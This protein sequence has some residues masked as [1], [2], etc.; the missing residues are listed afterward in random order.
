M[1]AIGAPRAPVMVYLMSEPL[2]SP[3]EFLLTG[4]IVGWDI[5][6]A[7]LIATAVL[8]VAGGLLVQWTTARKGPIAVGAAGQIPTTSSIG[9]THQHLATRPAMSA[10]GAAA[11]AGRAAGIVRRTLLATAKPVLLAIVAQA[12]ILRYL[13]TSWVSMTLGAN[14]ALAV[15][16][17]AAI[18][19]PVYV[20]AAGVAP[21][22][23]GLLDLGMDRGAA[24][25]FLIAGPITTV[26]AI[27]AVSSML[28]RR[29][30]A[31]Q[32][33][34]GFVGALVFGYAF[35]WF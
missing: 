21:L 33:A 18:G 27:L 16:M 9:C 30:I 5:A 15:P 11:I 20:N 24:L 23:R 3:G 25:A 29:F 2:F 22:V 35:R 28:G 26:P 7:K 17:A 4:G 14:P 34:V 10:E 1:V 32:I 19:I 8:A 12:V 31:V 6:I 13:P